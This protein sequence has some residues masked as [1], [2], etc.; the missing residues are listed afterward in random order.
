MSGMTIIRSPTP[1]C[2]ATGTVASAAPI[3]IVLRVGNH[4]PTGSIRWENRRIIVLLQSTI[5]EILFVNP[6]RKGSVRREVSQ[7]VPSRGQD[8]SYCMFMRM[9]S[10][11]FGLIM[12]GLASVSGT[13][14]AQQKV[15]R[16]LNVLLL[17]ADDLRPELG[18]YGV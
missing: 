12:A 14:L 10:Y 15:S 8:V 9:N 7:S 18:C 11:S 16:P 17:I 3:S 5:P 4:L 6:W 2:F 13:V 1:H